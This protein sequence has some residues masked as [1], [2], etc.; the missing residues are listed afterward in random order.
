MTSALD[1]DDYRE[2]SNSNLSRMD[3]RE[4]VRAFNRRAWE[5]YRMREA[6]VIAY[7]KMKKRGKRR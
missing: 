3:K 7:R 1:D 6:D 5:E 2:I 4:A